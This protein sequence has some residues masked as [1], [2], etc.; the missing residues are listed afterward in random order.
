MDAMAK[1]HWKEIAQHPGNRAPP[2]TGPL[3]MEGWTI[4]KEQ[5]KLAS[6]DKKYLYECVHNPKVQAWWVRHGRI[7]AEAL[8]RIDWE[9]IG[10][11]MKRMPFNRTKWL[12]KHASANCGIGETLV[13][14]GIQLD[15]DCPRCGEPETTT[16]VLQ[17][18]APSATTQWNTSTDK[19]ETWM[20]K[21]TTLPQLRKAIITNLS[22][23]RDG[24][25]ANFL[26]P[27]HQWP[28]VHQAV[29]DQDNIGWGIMLEG[30]ISRH[31]KETQ[32]EYYVWLDRRNTGRRWAELLIV[33]LINVAWDMWEQRNHTRHEPNNPR[34][35]KAINALNQALLAEL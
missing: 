22:L 25:P 34:L 6:M 16:H 4:W 8:H 29:H 5:Q 1:A 30:C 23:W 3:F 24:E 15:S 21:M 13:Q 31:W 2:Y 19:L 17:C 9:L 26:P 12:T 28:H 32:D 11:A 10:P 27:G 7:P 35:R 20:K 14:W 33:K 18:Q